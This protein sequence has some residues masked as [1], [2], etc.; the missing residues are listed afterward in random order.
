MKAL[1]R[2]EFEKRAVKHREAKLGLP[3]GW[4]GDD[5]RHVYGPSQICISFAASGAWSF[6]VGKQLISKHDDRT[7]AIRKARWYYNKFLAPGRK[8]KR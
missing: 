8:K 1:T 3:P 5:W 7:S 2:L 4:W 6:S